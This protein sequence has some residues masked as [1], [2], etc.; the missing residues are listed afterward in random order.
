MR[1]IAGAYRGRKLFSPAGVTTRPT[2]DRVK[3]SLFSILASRI[4]FN[5]VCVLDICAGTGSLGIEALSRGAESCCF[6]ESSQS[7]KAVLEKNIKIT[8]CQ[9]RTEIIAMD[10]VKALHVLAT[11]GRNFDLVF[12]D[13]PYDS[14]LYPSVLEKLNSYGMLKSGSILIAECSVRNPLLE[15]YGRLKRLDRRVYGETVLEL[16]VMEIL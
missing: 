11:H 7:V 10:A 1:V 16:F 6:I 5:D 3:E 4:D 2:S 15:S 9:D 13:P 8:C 12:F 14:R